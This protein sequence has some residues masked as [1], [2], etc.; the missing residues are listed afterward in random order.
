MIN[1]QLGDRIES[2]AHSV[3]TLIKIVQGDAPFLPNIGIE[4]TIS[5]PMRVN[6]SVISSVATTLNIGLPR[7][8]WR[9][10]ITVPSLA[11]DVKLEVEVV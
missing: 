10:M 11:G 5:S 6:T 7:I 8:R 9:R 4:G 1:Y 2:R 3:A